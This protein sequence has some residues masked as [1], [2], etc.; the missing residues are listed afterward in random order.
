[1]YLS[2]IRIKLC[3]D[4]LK[5]LDGLAKNDSYATHQ[6]LWNLFPDD[7]NAERDFLFREEQKEGWPLFYVMSSREASN[8][9]KLFHVETKLFNPEIQVGQRLAFDIRVNPVVARKVDG[10]KNS[11]YHD[12]WM[13]AK[14]KAKA[15]KLTEQKTDEFKQE[16]TIKWLADRSEK[17]GFSLEME[18]LQI[19]AYRQHSALKKGSRSLRYSTVDYSGILIVTDIEKFKS[20]LTNGLGRAKAFGC[21]LMLIKNI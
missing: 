17:N 7:K 12:V 16:N 13:D 15:E 5:Y 3:E 9:S 6:L 19:N 1:M 14:H 21:G 8:S 10:K 20:I 4:S 18:K 11:K 2:R